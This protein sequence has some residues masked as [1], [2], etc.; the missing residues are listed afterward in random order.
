MQMSTSQR[1]RGGELSD[2]ETVPFEF[3]GER[4][5][6]RRGESLEAA[7]TAAGIRALRTTRNDAGS[8]CGDRCS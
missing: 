6:G 5:F 7:L 1:A 4:L 3:E 2:T 8:R